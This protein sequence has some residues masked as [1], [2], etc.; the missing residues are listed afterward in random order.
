MRSELGNTVFR[1]V[2]FQSRGRKLSSLE[3]QG[4]EGWVVIGTTLRGTAITW[5]HVGKRGR[6]ARNHDFF[7]LSET[8]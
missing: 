5:L 3:K 8:L 2:L 7:F 1:Y 6:G 4:G